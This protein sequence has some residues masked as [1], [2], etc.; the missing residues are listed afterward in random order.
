MLIFDDAKQ[1]LHRRIA[2]HIQE[3]LISDHISIIH[4]IWNLSLL[5]IPSWRWPMNRAWR[6]FVCCSNRAPTAFLPAR[7]ARG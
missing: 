3:R 7:S 2:G 1:C 4:E 6:S 5:L